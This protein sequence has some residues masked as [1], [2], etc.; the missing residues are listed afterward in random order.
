MRA[1][2]LALAVVA[3]A[4]LWSA[5]TVS[6]TS[7]GDGDAR[8]P[9]LAADLEGRPINLQLIGTFYC[10]D[11]DFP[12][13]HCYRTPGALARAERRWGAVDGKLTTESAAFGVNDYV[14][15][16]DGSAYTGAGMDVSQ[17]YDALFSIGWNDRISSYKGRNSANGEFWTDWFASGT[18]RTFC[19]NTMVSL[20]PSNLDNAFSSVYRH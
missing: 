19:C 11:F 6:A 16:F 17:N 18:G 2:G 5:T 20:L 7:P 1:A 14:S 8:R 12:N 10:H 4:A 9:Q 13:I 3:T 15:I